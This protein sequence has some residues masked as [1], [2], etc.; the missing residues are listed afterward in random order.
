MA[1]EEVNLSVNCPVVAFLA[2][3]GLK[4]DAVLLEA[5]PVF[6]VVADDKT[7]CVN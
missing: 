5:G 6:A 2:A 4:D 1:A 7:F 3:L